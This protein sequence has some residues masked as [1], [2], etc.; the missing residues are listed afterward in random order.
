[1]K[2]MYHS[3]R[4]V[5]SDLSAFN[6]LWHRG[7]VHFID[8]S[9]SVEP[10]H[11]HGL[12][13][14][15]RDCTNVSNFFRKKGLGEVP[16]PRQL[17]SDITELKIAVDNDQELLIQVRSHAFVSTLLRCE[18]QSP[19]SSAGQE[20]PEGASGDGAYQGGPR[21]QRLRLLLWSDS[22]GLRGAV[23]QFGQRGRLEL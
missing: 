13:F 5:H 6:M 7:Q 10:A 18:Q 23:R 4:L 3:C 17:F 2:K 22:N 12:E 20:L 16:S 1:M 21:G 15:L 11:V 14:L 19:Y 8:V 9:Q